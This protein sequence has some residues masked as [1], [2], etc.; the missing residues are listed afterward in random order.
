MR[1]PLPPWCRVRGLCDNLLRSRQGFALPAVMGAIL[2]IVALITGVLVQARAA[3]R[4]ARLDS[5]VV[6][7]QTVVWSALQQ[8]AAEIQANVQA[9]GTVAVDAY[10]NGGLNPA[11][12]PAQWPTCTL[13]TLPDS[14]VE[15]C[16]DW[17][18][19]MAGSPDWGVLEVGSA[20]PGDVLTQ[21][22]IVIFWRLN[23]ADEVKAS[24]GWVLVDSTPQVVYVLA[25]H[26]WCRVKAGWLPGDEA[27]DMGG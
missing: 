17:F 12:A 19:A 21:I 13:Q 8:A 15:M 6:Q 20:W 3:L 27:C 4:L 11:V 16:T 14:E 26:Q 18:T 10:L 9:N 7:S 25:D 23:A 1:V 22:P 5:D 2:V 24:Y